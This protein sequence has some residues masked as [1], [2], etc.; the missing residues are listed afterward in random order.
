MNV[1]P[2][3]DGFYHVHLDP[4]SEAQIFA[5]QAFQRLNTALPDYLHYREAA[6]GHLLGMMFYRNTECPRQDNCDATTATDVNALYS[7]D[8]HGETVNETSVP[9]HRA[10]VMGAGAVYEKFLDESKYITEAGVTGKIG[11]FDIVNNGLAIM[12]DRIR[13]ILR[14]PLDRLQQMVSQ[15]WSWSGGF[16]V[17]SDVTSGD[18]ARFKRAVVI[19][20]GA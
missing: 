12:I 20:H 8:I 3:P 5:D 13:Y 10:I 16:P 4:T 17:P 6:L 9:I 19:E 15:S 7:I 18:D 14:S 1:P 11:S 2:F